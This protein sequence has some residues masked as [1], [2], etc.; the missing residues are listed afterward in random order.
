LSWWSRINNTLRL[1]TETAIAP[2]A[3]VALLAQ[4]REE[5]RN[6]KDFKLSDE[7]RVKISNLGW[8]VRDTKEGQQLARR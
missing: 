3:E 6:Q 4:Q 2:P 1:E 8:E 5:A 7:L